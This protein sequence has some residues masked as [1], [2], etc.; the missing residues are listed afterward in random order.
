[1]KKYLVQFYYTETEYSK[2]VVYSTKYCMRPRLTNEYKSLLEML[3]KDQIFSFGYKKG[4]YV[5]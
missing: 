1:M 5:D 2:D 4:S 3:D